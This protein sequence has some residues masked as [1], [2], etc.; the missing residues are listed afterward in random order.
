MDIIVLIY[1]L[2]FYLLII[3]VK[4]LEKCYINTFYL[5]AVHIQ[6]LLFIALSLHCS[7]TTINIRNY[8]K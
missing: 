4:H 5:H 1:Y 8:A 7:Y 6:I 3:V 2:Y